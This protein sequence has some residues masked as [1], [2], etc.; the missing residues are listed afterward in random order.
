MFNIAFVVAFNCKNKGFECFEKR[1]TFNICDRKSI[2]Y[3]RVLFIV[4]T[5]F[6]YVEIFIRSPTQN[7]HNDL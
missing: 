5:N 4:K 7:K 6:F 2:Y 3:M 1:R